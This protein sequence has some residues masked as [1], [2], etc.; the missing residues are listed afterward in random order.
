MDA[1]LGVIG[2]LA[3]TIFAVD[4]IRDQRRSPRRTSPPM[5]PASHV[6][7]RH[8]GIRLR[9][10]RRLDGLRVPDVLPLRGDPQH[11]GAG[12]RIDV[13]RGRTAV[14]SRDDGGRGGH[15]RHLDHAHDHRPVRQ[16]PPASG[17]PSDIFPPISDGFGPRLLAAISGGTGATILIVLS[18]VSVFRFWRSNRRIVIG[19]ALILAGTL[20]ASFQ[21]TVLALGEEGAFASS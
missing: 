19:N 16:A 9:H 14:G 11:P 2:G 10:H 12:A 13:P 17:V 3:S 6:R 7:H 20:V 1:T 15:R 4:L 18:L 8:L 5:R 21:G